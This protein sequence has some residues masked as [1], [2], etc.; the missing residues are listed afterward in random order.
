MIKEILGDGNITVNQKAEVLRAERIKENTY[1]AKE[2]IEVGIQLYRTNRELEAVNKTLK[3]IV[4]DLIT[5]LLERE[6]V[7]ELKSNKA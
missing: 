7:K 6:R 4:D 5:K 3:L 1:L 2:L